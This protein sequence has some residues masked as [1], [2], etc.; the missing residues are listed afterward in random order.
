MQ[1]PCNPFLVIKERLQ[2]GATC[3]YMPNG[4]NLG[5]CLIAS[6]TIQCFESYQIP[7]KYIRGNRQRVKPGDL[8]VYGGGGSLV[9]YYQGGIECIESLLALGAN[10]IVLPQTINGHDAF[11]RRQCSIT[12]FCRDAAS[13][14]YLSAYK[15]ISSFFAHDIATCLDLSQEPFSSITSLHRALLESCPRPSLSV[16]RNDAERRISIKQEG[17]IDLPSVAYPSMKSTDIIHANSCILLALLAGYSKIYTDRLHVAIGASLLDI[18]V[19]LYDTSHRKNSSV[20][21]STLQLLYPRV[22]LCNPDDNTM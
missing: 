2:P 11:W 19:D 12:V 18:A 14:H 16:F 21:M 6:A 13:L 3:Y 8:L 10:V 17:T 7:W 5:D 20:Y 9:S 22:R 15:D 4:G 1:E